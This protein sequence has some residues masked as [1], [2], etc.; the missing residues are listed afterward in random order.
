MQTRNAVVR[1]GGLLLLM[2]GLLAGALLPARAVDA[3][4]TRVI[5]RLQPGAS[6]AELNRRYGSTT[7]VQGPNSLALLALPASTSLAALQNDTAVVFA[8]ADVDTASPESYQLSIVSTGETLLM[9][10]DGGTIIFNT[11]SATP[12]GAYA[13]QWAVGNTKMRQAQQVA[14]GAGVVVAVLDTGIDP[15]HPVFRDRL[16][17]GWDFVGNDANPSEEGDGLDDDGDGQVDENMGHGTHVAGIVVLTAPRVTVMPVRVLNADG[18]GSYFDVVRGIYWAVDNG[19]RIINLSLSAPFPSR[20]LEE[21]VN[22][23]VSRR[24][25]LVAAAGPEGG[26][27]HYPAA[28]APVL[29]VGAID[30]NNRVASFSRFTPNQVDVYAPGVA[31]MSAYHNSRYVGW[32]GTSMAAPFVAGEAALL[33]QIRPSWSLDLLS[34][35]IRVTVKSV[36]PGHSD[37]RGRID[38][39]MA[40]RSAPH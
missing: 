19:A 22:Y 20:A 31:I 26:A 23:A 6:L 15:N 14:S 7:L 33:A 32:S 21:A 18:R 38:M 28:Y 2:L 34:G 5:V 1:T 30:S 36:N 24:V 27:V 9:N 3:G 16:T 17:A 4:P 40:I 39:N 35:W 12:P 29:A 25:L 8:E 10:A 37:G 13:D 11:D